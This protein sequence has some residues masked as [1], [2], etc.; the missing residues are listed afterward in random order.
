[1]SPIIPTFPM[2][3]SLRFRSL[4]SKTKAARLSASN[5]LDG[6]DLQ[7]PKQED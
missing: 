1:M 2:R 7:R 5:T 6:P 3:E 4:L